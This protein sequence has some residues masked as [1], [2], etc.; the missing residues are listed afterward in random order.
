MSS[1]TR[2][3]CSDAQT[4]SLLIE[5]EKPMIYLGE[6]LLFQSLQKASCYFLS[7][8]LGRKWQMNNLACRMEVPS[9]WSCVTLLNLCVLHVFVQRGKWMMICA[10]FQ[11]A[12]GPHSFSQASLAHNCESVCVCVVK[13]NRVVW[14]LLF[15]LSVCVCLYSIIW[16]PHKNAHAWVE[17]ILFLKQPCVQFKFLY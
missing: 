6:T 9:P 5:N 13:G 15:F 3:N 11:A 2:N 1:K 12:H 14:K 7:L 16:A 17:T 8:S 4:V 10:S